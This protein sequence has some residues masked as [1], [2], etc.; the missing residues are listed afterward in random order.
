MIVKGAGRRVPDR[1]F[2]SGQ[3]GLVLTP[4]GGCTDTA[5]PR[6]PRD[7]SGHSGTAPSVFRGPA[8]HL[9]R[10]GLRW[11]SAMGS[12]RSLRYCRSSPTPFP[13][14]PLSRSG[15]ARCHGARMGG[16]LPGRCSACSAPSS[17]PKLRMPDKGKS[18][19]DDTLQKVTRITPRHKR[20][21]VHVGFCHR[22][23]ASFVVQATKPH[24]PAGLHHIHGR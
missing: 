4:K 5:C 18:G 15:S 14:S 22:G 1:G 7:L 20:E 13:R 11:R 2:S 16:T 24:P 8:L 17:P 23:S 9:G 21:K 6:V 12:V 3:Q 10:C 19:V